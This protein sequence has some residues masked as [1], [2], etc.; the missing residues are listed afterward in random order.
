MIYDICNTMQFVDIL[1]F[2]NY[3]SDSELVYAILF[4]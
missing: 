4:T 3:Y 2:L 1:V